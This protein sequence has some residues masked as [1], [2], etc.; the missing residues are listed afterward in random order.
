MA[1]V[2]DLYDILGVGRDASED[3]IKRAYRRLARELHPDVNGSTEAE[4]RFKEVA[5]AYEIL[6]DP[7]KRQRYDAF[8]ATGG[9]Q[10]SPFTDVQDIFDLFFGAGG[11]GGFGGGRTR[12]TRSRVWHGED[13]R[14]SVSLGF[15]E[16]AFGSHQELRIERAVVCDR[17]L[18]N[19]AEPGT[20]PVACRTCGGTGQ[21]Q[22][23]RRSIF[24]AVMTSTPCPTCDGTGQEILDRCEACRGEGRRREPAT[25]PLDVPA[26]VAD[27][28]ELR[29]AGAGHAGRGGGPAGDLYVAIHVEPS[30]AFDR[31]GQDLFTVLDV[32]LPTVVLGG[33]IEIE[34][35]DERERI[36]VEPGTESGTIVRLKGKGIP[37][38]NRRGRGDLYVTLHVVTPTHLSKEERALFERFA[39]L[40]GQGSSRRDP[41]EGE[42]RRPAE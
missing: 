2:R 8:G 4:E 37:N 40:R 33:E 26:G 13:L 41:I 7:E 16:A 24:G 6:S 35:L 28:M 27:G 38:V 30:V 11:F 42:L 25:V 20:A 9:P 17:C 12:G 3:E 1:A 18:G 5:G 23:M 15:K 10:G 34:G 19:G 36:H 21:L 29:I 39:D 31:R 14:A 22:Q 32:P